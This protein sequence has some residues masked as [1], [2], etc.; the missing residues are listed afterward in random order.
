M[1]IEFPCSG[2]GKAMRAPDGSAGRSARCPLCGTTQTIPTADE[3]DDIFPSIE[4]ARLSDD[5]PAC[6][7]P[8]HRPVAKGVVPP[9]RGFWGDAILSFIVPFRGSGPFLFGLLVLMHI[10]HWLLGFGGAFGFAGRVIITGWLCGYYLNVV[11]ETCAGQ[12]E[13]PSF[14][15]TE[16]VWDDILRPTFLFL[17]G[18]VVALLPMLV[19]LA[20][21]YLRDG[22]LGGVNDGLVGL[23]LLGV[24]LF[25]W[26]MTI[27]TIS[28]HG[29]SIRML[30]YDQQGL[31]IARA[32]PQYLV[33]WILLIALTAGW[34][35]SI[36]ATVTLTGIL[37]LRSIS[38]A[39]LVLVTG[40]AFFQGYFATVG[41]RIIGLYYRHYKDRF[42]WVAE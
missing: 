33:I 30:R 25:F 35:V 6:E 36:V 26:P 34:W 31:S 17:G 39:I 5:S 9:A 37:G 4:P 42:T 27:L 28:V 38:V 41:M 13:L 12:D 24:G 29:F 11:L 7:P 14:T 3:G 21:V 8:M 18:T 32:F 20:G 2:C 23:V 16:G 15:I 1:A 10:F 40:T 19:W 22:I